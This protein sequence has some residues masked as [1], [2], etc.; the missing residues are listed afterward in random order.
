M[1]IYDFQLI[2]PTILEYAANAKQQLI[3]DI[4]ERGKAVVVSADAQYAHPGHSSSMGTVTIMD[5]SSG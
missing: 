5:V 4:I 2:G 3:N 1:D